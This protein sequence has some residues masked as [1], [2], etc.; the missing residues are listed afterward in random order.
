MRTTL[1][2]LLVLLLLLPAGGNGPDESRPTEMLFFAQGPEGTPFELE[3]QGNDPDCLAFSTGLSPDLV[4]S[5]GRGFQSAVAEHLFPNNFLAPYFFIIEN[6]L[7]PVRGVFRNLSASSP[8]N[9]QRL[10]FGGDLLTD[11]QIEPGECRSI[12]TFSDAD[13][14]VAI[15]PPP[16]REVRVD[17]CSFDRDTELPENFRCGDAP[18]LGGTLPVVDRN[19]IFFASIGDLSGT[20][21]TQ[22]LLIQAGSRNDCQ[23]PATMFLHDAQDSI[24]IVI[25]PV[26]SQTRPDRLFHGDLYF[27]GER[28]DSDTPSVGGDV[29]L[30]RDI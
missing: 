24:S 8:L 13:E 7:Q 10:L 1:W 22:C 19:A 3:R 26:T 20:N 30:T 15:P 28:V 2:R 25:S 12:T 6:E 4:P 29:I 11:V 21:R 9:V 17:V 27:D 16:S 18:A 23:T 5:A 14:A